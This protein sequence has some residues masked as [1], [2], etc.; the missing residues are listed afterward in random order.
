MPW[1]DVS[2]T[3]THT[4]LPLEKLS[5]IFFIRQAPNGI[6]LGQRDLLEK[7][8]G[9]CWLKTTSLEHLGIWMVTV[10]TEFVAPPEWLQAQGLLHGR[11]LE[12]NCQ[13]N[14][15]PD[16]LKVSP[17]KV[18][19]PSFCGDRRDLEAPVSCPQRQPHFLH[20]FCECPMALPGLGENKPKKN[21]IPS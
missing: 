13:F 8:G 19:F 4:F 17:L 15:G 14:R 9:G 10:S 7:G 16:A 1:K 5:V 3:H 12:G 21:R 2:S 6:S 11:C 20:E 18:E